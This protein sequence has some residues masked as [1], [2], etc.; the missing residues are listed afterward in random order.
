MRCCWAILPLPKLNFM[1]KSDR[2]FV[3]ACYDGQVEA[4]ALMLKSGQFDGNTSTSGQSALCAA[5]GVGA[6]G[7]A[8]RGEIKVRLIRLLVPRGAKSEQIQLAF[9]R[10]GS[11]TVPSRASWTHG[12]HQSMGYGL[13]YIGGLRNGSAVVA[14]ELLDQG[15][16]VD[17]LFGMSHRSS[18]EDPRYPTTVIDPAGVRRRTSDDQTS[19]RTRGQATM[20]EYD[21]RWIAAR[22]LV[23]GNAH[24]VTADAGRILR[25]YY[26]VVVH[27]NKEQGRRARART[28]RL[29]AI[30]PWCRPSPY[31]MMP[32]GCVG[33]Q[34]RACGLTFSR[35]ERLAQR[36]VKG[37]LHSWPQT[38]P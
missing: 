15:A 6:A 2:D 1:A 7:R 24:R 10:G 37:R 23:A 31:V 26:S 21:S 33:A 28:Q 25:Q 36:K 13:P 9:C 16:D 4:V 12:L 22:R 11:T 32:W 8:G 34:R 3:V 5:A 27:L 14:T 20:L 17:A 30:D 29:S 18:G 38:H 35:L 19:R